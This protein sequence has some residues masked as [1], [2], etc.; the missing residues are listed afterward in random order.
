MFER[1][2]AR[3]RLFVEESMKRPPDAMLPWESEKWRVFP[4]EVPGDGNTAVS[5][6]SCDLEL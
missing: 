5:A 2:D 3:S 4:K 6:G 1:D